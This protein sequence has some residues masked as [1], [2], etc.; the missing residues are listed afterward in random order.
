MNRLQIQLGFV[1]IL[2]ALV[3][4][5]GMPF[6]TSARLGLAAHTVGISG[7]LVLIV[8]GALAPA[9]VL[10]KRA[11]AVM[12]GSWLYA[13]YA[14]WFASLL[15][16]ITGA[17]RLTPIA[18][19][20]TKGDAMAETIVSLLLESLSVAALL[21]T[22]LAIYGFRKAEAVKAAQAVVATP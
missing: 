5:F 16:A 11:S 8:L 12:M 15:G 4:G 20:G 7:G 6:F 1:L 14:N 3:T 9:F 21:G 13:A 22:A 10:G 2:L 17:S 19:A 18:G